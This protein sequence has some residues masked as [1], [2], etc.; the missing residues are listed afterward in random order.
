MTQSANPNPNP[1]PKIEAIIWDF[2]GVF[3]S[4]PFEAFNVLEAEVGAPK[5]FI[6][7][8]NAVNPEINAWAQFESNS[9]SMD[10]FDELFAAESEAKGHRIPGKA[11]IARLSGTLRPRMV[12]V[13]KICKQHF[14][15]ACITNNV[16]AGHGPGMDTD[17]AKANSV[18]SVMEIF[19]LVVESSK[20]GIRK[21]NPE[22]Y[23]RTC[24]KLG[25]SPTKAVFLD[26]L[27]INLKPAKNLGMQ[28]IKVLGED[29]AIAD[30]AK[31]TGLTFD[32]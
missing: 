31:V 12:E 8:I 21:P 15:V 4:S 13:L 17:Q 23:T 2:G 24:E 16:K 11:V 30:L 3:T 27:G 7:G 22:I 10:D 14:M 5:D 26:D 28:T 19:S 18:A 6:R 9:V 29:Q 25:V 32:V 1:N 20:E